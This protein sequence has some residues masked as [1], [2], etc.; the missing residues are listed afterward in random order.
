MPENSSSFTVFFED[1]FWVGWYQ[2]VEN[3]KLTV[4]RVVFGPEP[5]DGEVYQ[6]LLDNWH[7]F[8]FGPAVSTTSVSAIR[9]PKRRLRAV[10]KQLEKSPK[11]ST[12]A[13]QALQKQQEETKEKRKASTKIR[14][15]EEKQRQ[16]QLRQQKK[17]EK[18]KGR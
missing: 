2:R 9:N 12:K 3:G 10:R 11:T 7:R 14:Q 8:R 15:E 18:H 6:F 16:F 17:L 5:R 13:Q 4:C 1:P